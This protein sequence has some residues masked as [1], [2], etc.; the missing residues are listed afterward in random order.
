MKAAA[1]IVVLLYLA[2]P[3]V[4]EAQSAKPSSAFRIARLKYSGGGDWYNG[5]TEEPNLLR[6]VRQHTLIDVEPTYEFVEI[7]SD[8]LFTYP[9]VFMT[10]HGNIVL[11]DAEARRLRTYLENGGFLYADDDYGM[12]QAFRREIR[13]VF[14]D[15]QLVELPFSYGLFHCHFT[16]PAGTPKIH[17]H[18]GKPPQA[19]GLFHNGRLVVLYTYESNPSDGWDDPDVHNTPTDKRDEALR[20]GTNIVVWSLT[21]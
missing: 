19:F 8:R 9:F 21:N 10:G 6:Y 12:D 3:P 20:F 16:F 14:P 7:T 1:I 13:K 2:L 15:Q 4:G 17:E 18:D 11:S 5:P